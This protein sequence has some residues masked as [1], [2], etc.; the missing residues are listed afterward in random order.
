MDNL[1]NRFHTLV[2]TRI[3]YLQDFCAFGEDSIR[4]DFYYAL[5]QQYNLLPH[6]II[7]EQ[8]IPKSQYI[9]K[10][11]NLIELKQGRHEDKPEF[12]LR[13][14]GT[15]NL[16]NGLLCEFAFFRNPLI[17]KLDVSGAYGKIL[18]EIHRLALLKHYRNIPNLDGYKDFSKYKCLMVCITDSGMLEYGNGKRGRKPAYLVQDRYKLDDQFLSPP[19]ANV[20][21]DAVDA[22]FRMKAMQLK[23]IPT[24]ERIYNRVENFEESKW[25]IWIWEVD[26]ISR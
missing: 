23:I 16:Q 1:F 10:E 24:A 9:Q 5:M 13:V 17:G 4:Y 25:G 15:N 14:D 7:L 12:D 26:Y 20:I 11:R 3:N 19:L 22:R 8:A 2:Q 6:Q 18:N 21:I